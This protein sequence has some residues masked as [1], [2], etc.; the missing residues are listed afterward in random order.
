MVLAELHQLESKSLVVA[1]ESCLDLPTAGTPSLRLGAREEK[2]EP[3][4]AVENE[5]LSGK[6]VL[7]GDF[8][9]ILEDLAIA[10]ASALIF[11]KECL[12]AD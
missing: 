8:Q 12:A 1:G 6:L 9:E 11:K 5:L 10:A 2:V 7:G 3:L 4:G